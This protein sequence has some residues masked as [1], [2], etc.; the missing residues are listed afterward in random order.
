MRVA[1]VQLTETA[2]QKDSHNLPQRKKETH[3]DT[4]RELHSPH[5][6]K[7]LSHRPKPHLCSVTTTTTVG[8]GRKMN[9]LPKQAQNK[10]ILKGQFT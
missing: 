10:N 5:A 9:S 3:T 7:T 1:E 8:R 2:H 6:T 4:E